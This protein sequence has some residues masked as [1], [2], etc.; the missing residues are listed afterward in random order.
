MGLLIG[1]GGSKPS[2]AYDYYYGIEWDMTVKNGIPKRVGKMELH[3]S[4]PLQSMM[5]R[6]L[7]DDQGN[8]TNYL[9]AN[10]S[11]R[12]DN[13][14]ASDLTGASGQ[15]MVELPDVY[16]KFEID[17]NLCRHLQSPY[18]L[19]GFHLWRKDY[20]SAV[21]ATVQRSTNKLCA[22]VNKDPDFRGG[23][24]QKDWDA[25]PKTML[26]KPA[27]SISLT[28]FRAYA[29]KR[30]TTEWN[31]QLYQT[32][33]KLWWLFAV[34]YCTFDSQSDFNA[35]LT[36]EGF[37]QGGLGA[38]VTDLDGSKW[39]AFSGYNPVIPCGITNSLG[40]KTGVV[41]YA[42]PKEYDEVIKTTHVPSYRGVENP[43]GHIWKWTDGCKCIIQS[44]TSGG[45]SKFFVCDNPDAFASSGLVDYNHKGNLP[46]GNGYV[47]A[48]LLGEDGEIMPKEVGGGS[49]VYFHDYFYTSVPTDG[50]SERGVLFGGIAYYG[51]S[52][53]FV[54]A[55]T[56]DSPSATG[57]YFGS[58]LCF[59]PNRGAEK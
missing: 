22:V 50:E 26:G 53:G 57:A 56:N 21:E 58:R 28:N 45:L 11:S 44:E 30:G 54:F 40:N 41:D 29:R 49:T 47:K 38:G 7:L 8:V 34:E 27:T 10:D 19:P 24:N 39:S 13:G 4:L 48:L 5:R 42:M 15:Y 55:R 51:A 12:Y 46:R 31:C 2:F 6:C 43:F 20:I 14:S 35:G 23:G 3:K 9:D 32:Y 37:H 25:L 1:V 36:E 33:R 17:G 52:A 18:P 59:Y 16:V